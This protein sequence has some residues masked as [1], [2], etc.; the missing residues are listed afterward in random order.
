[1]GTWNFHYCKDLN[2]RI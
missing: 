1:M 2:M